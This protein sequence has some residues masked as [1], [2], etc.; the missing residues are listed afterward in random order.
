M[1]YLVTE[2]RDDPVLLQGTLDQLAYAGWRLVQVVW[3]GANDVSG[4]RVS[5]YII[6]SARHDEQ[7]QE[8]QAGGG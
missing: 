8:R 1:R 2:C 4:Y 7:P 5:H 6:I 3:H